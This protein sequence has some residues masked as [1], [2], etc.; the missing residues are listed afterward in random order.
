MTTSVRSV[1]EHPYA[2]F[3]HRVNKP[4][5]YTG[6]EVGAV[7]KDWASV[8][9]TVCLA[10]PDVYDIGM[11]HLGF[12]IL[13]KVLNDD[14]RTL[15]ERAY[16]PWVDVEREL[17]DRALP[18]VS[19]DT[20]RPLSDFDVIGFSLQ[21]ELTYTNILTMLDLGGVPLRTADRGEDDALILAGGPNATH[22]E[23]LAAFIDAFCIGDGEEKLKEVALLWT[24]LRTAGVPRA[25][26]LRALAA[27][28]AV[29]VPS[30]YE[31]EEDPLSGLLVVAEPEDPSVPFP[32]ER[33]MVDINAYPFPDD[34][35]TGGPEAIFDRTS[36]EITRGCTEGCRFCQAGM[37]YRPVQER[38]PAHVE[39]VVRKSLAHS[40]NDE[41]SLT[42]LST[43]DVSYIHPLIS[44]L[45]PE[46][47]E[48]GVSLSVSSLRAYGLQPEL[49]DELKRVRAGGLTFAPEA[50]TERMRAV[51][52]KNVTEAQLME[53]A[54]R[55]FARGWQRMKLYFMV[56]LPS[57]EDEDVQG[58][59]QTGSRTAEVGKEVGG[60]RVDVTVSVS[61][62]VPKPHTPF[63]W[64]AMDSLDEIR[65]KHALLREEARAQ[66]RVKKSR[67]VKL[68]THDS[69]S[70]VL[71]GIFAR[72]DRRLSDV[73]ERAYHHGA[74]F[75]SWDEQL[76]LDVWEEALQHYAIPQHRYLGT[77][78]VPARLPW[79]HIDVG[80]E[81]GF[82]L[83][84]YRKALHNRLSPPCGKVAGTFIHHTNLAAAEA[85]R[86]RLVCY[87][88]G[89]ACDMSTMRDDRLVKLRRLDAFGPPTS[90]SSSVPA[91]ASVVTAEPP[92]KSGPKV[93]DP[94]AGYRYRFRFEKKGA[95]A[96]LGHLDLVRE[97]PRIFRRLD[98]EQ[99]HTGGYHP[100]P[101]MSFAPALSLG[102]M[103][104]DEYVDLRLYPRYDPAGLR[105][106]IADMNDRSPAG[107]VFLAARRF[108]RRDPPIGRVVEGARLLLAFARDVFPDPE[109]L[110]RR[111]D[112]LMARE[113]LE[114]RRKVKGLHRLLDLR[115]RLFGL[116]VLEDARP[117]LARAGVA[118]DLIGV[119]ATVHI[120][121][122]GS[123][124]AAEIA[125]LLHAEPSPHEV[126]D[127]P[128]HRVIRLALFGA[129]PGD[130]A[131]G[132]GPSPLDLETFRAVPQRGRLGSGAA[133]VGGA[134][135]GAADV[136]G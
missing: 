108:E 35:P 135:V 22:P 66:R 116:R 90:S 88:C 101:D 73:I 7:R 49:L 136:R 127:P 67:S 94:D 121:P 125:A 6:G 53:T 132:H 81:D 42:A 9:A 80:L 126:P 96:L 36:I 71:E 93:G 111:C 21:Y 92:K 87:D 62:H 1:E 41:V 100:K 117:W 32:I 3:L 60:R 39:E 52:N 5:R 51:V 74:R 102:A 84:E 112:A 18:L 25:E 30:L 120:T 114:V 48:K 56:G 26:R 75:D 38:D 55:V 16:C 34:S 8:A 20:L 59:V 14:P 128:P 123:V 97:L 43:A 69:E 50:G 17:R 124:R 13:Y 83:R 85:D 31:V 105:A 134:E 77:I 46:L 28:G 68:R 95:V 99:V 54:E 103:S 113:T 10:F 40:G 86:R 110:Q 106:L 98:V 133:R 79:S 4:A 45:A 33:A 76:R 47:A 130:Q 61:T 64:C 72:G 122:R 82:L 44:R 70:S 11:S 63:Q 104:L 78:P 89:V 65:R 23:P 91:P 119:E 12:K 118:G 15:A 131:S 29:Y 58:I 37:I 19:L 2:A 24:E 129:A 115:P 109:A 57:E 27:L 107:L